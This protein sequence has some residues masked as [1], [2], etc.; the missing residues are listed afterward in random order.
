M[1]H[2]EHTGR[3]RLAL[4][5]RSWCPWRSVALG[6]AVIVGFLLLAAPELR[7]PIVGLLA[8]VVGVP[9]GVEYLSWRGGHAVEQ[10]QPD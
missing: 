4:H 8:L 2:I 1:Q 5:P 9:L 3:R 6:L 7:L 10:A